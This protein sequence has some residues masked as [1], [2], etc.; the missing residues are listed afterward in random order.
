[1]KSIGKLGLWLSLTTA[2]S[3]A[4]LTPA[5]AADVCPAG[6]L[7]VSRTIEVDTAGGPW[8]GE[9]HGDRNFLAQ[10]EV[11][12]TFDDGPSPRDTREILAALAKECTKAT[13]FM[14]GEMVAVHPEIVKEVVNAG[15]TI[16]THTWSHPNVARLALPELT[17]EVESTFDIVEKNSPGSVAPFFRYPYLSSSKLAEDYFK[18]RNIGQFAVDIDSSDWRVHSSSAV[19]ARIMGGLKRRGRGIILMHDIHKWTADSV[20][21]LLQKLKAGGYKV[22]ALKAK[23]PV[24][25]IA[26]VTPPEKSVTNSV[27]RKGRVRR[28]HYRVRKSAL[29]DRKSS[30]VQ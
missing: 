23:A 9:P 14:V 3:A 13:F 19:V 24:Q 15:H 17:H 5:L 20:P 12:L 26:D 6:A 7:G 2:A 29:L 22:V 16:G 8:F 10:G 25:L 28:S 27:S 4:L 21:Q 1:M 11:V 30:D 18:S